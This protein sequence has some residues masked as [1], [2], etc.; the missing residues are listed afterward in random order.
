[1]TAEIEAVDFKKAR[2]QKAKL[3]DPLKGDRLP[4]HSVEA[5]Q[6]VLGCVLLSPADSLDHCTQKFAGPEVFYDLRH[7][8]IYEALSDMH[9]RKAHIDMITVQQSLKD[10]QQLESVGGLSYLTSL[11]DAVPSA[12]NLDYYL[13]I[14]REKYALREHVAA[15][16]E[17]VVDAYEHQGELEEVIARHGERFNRV[18]QLF[19]AD[20]VPTNKVVMRSLVEK[21]D[22]AANGTLPKGVRTG[23]VDL[24]RWT[25]GLKP[26]QLMVVAARPS[27]GKSSLGLNIADHVAAVLG[28]P[29]A[30]FSLEMGR[31]EHI[32][33]AVCARARVDSS[34]LN[35]GVAT[36][37]EMKDV[38]A[39]QSA[40]AKAPIHI[41]D[42]PG[43]SIAQ[44]SGLAR[45]IT[46]RHGIK[47][48]VVDH[49]GLV[50]CGERG[51]S[52]YEEITKVSGAL[53][54]LAMELRVPVLALAQLNRDSDKE[55]REPRMSDLRDSGSIEQDADILALLHPNAG[56]T[57]DPQRVKLIV[58]K[59]RGGRTGVINL[60][61]HRQYTRFDSAA[62]ERA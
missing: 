49:L 3:T 53:K 11:P 25:G 23:F 52:R 54:A 19:S 8:T 22:A 17:S 30:F 46:Q 55:D 51:R 28:E 15:C 31:E 43:L 60:V 6:G 2:R 38:I 42:K 10:K 13:E 1:M 40:I 61:F 5:E 20:T 32:E 57:T 4:P 37:R 35:Q 34:R 62:K 50:N 39:A 21:W 41:V 18:R 59:H 58:A 33:R 48:I 45:S 47:L 26:K 14:V 56:D 7:R 24:D 44:L 12:A 36:E 29:V 9:G 27:R 16:T